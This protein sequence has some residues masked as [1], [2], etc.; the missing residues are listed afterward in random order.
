VTVPEAA[1]IDSAF[2][3]RSF[4]AET[5]LGT[6]PTDDVDSLDELRRRLE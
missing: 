4:T 5:R 6:G 1:G 2:V 3:R